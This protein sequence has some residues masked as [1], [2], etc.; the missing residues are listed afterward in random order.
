[1]ENASKYRNYCFTSWIIPDCSDA[2]ISYCIYQEE[3][4]PKSGKIHYQGYAELSSQMRLTELK[5]AMKNDTMHIEPRMGTQAQAIAYCMKDDTQVSKPII[6]GKPKMQGGRSDLESISEAIQNGMTC[7]EILMEFG[8]NALR[9]VN[10]IDKALQAHHR[11]L[12]I[13]MFILNNRN[14]SEVDG[15]TEP[16]NSEAN[17]DLVRRTILTKKEYKRVQD[18]CSDKLV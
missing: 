13:D 10:H 5:K 12:P 11:C 2:R 1:M 9:V 14:A 8:G 3:K 18:K 16:S 6:Y 17:L 15:N 4:C 7:R